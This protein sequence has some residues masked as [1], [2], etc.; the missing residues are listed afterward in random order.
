MRILLTQQVIMGQAGRF[1][2]GNAQPD[3][4][5]GF[6]NDLSY[7]GFSLSIFFYYVYGNEVYNN[8][9][10][11]IE[12]DGQRYGWNHLAAAGTDYWQQPGDIVS[13]PQP[14]PGGNNSSNSRSTRYI[15]DGSFLRLRNVTF[16]YNFPF[17]LLD[18][19][20]IQ[21]VRLYVQGQ[22]LW[23]LTDYSGFDPEMD[24]SGSEFFRYPV[25][26]SFTFGIDLTF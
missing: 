7:Q 10:R 21:N 1:I 2:I 24:E 18:K 12:S 8:S 15:E 13:R 23:T 20:G 6:T 5:G 4:T 16:S 9:R 19:A 22:N 25:G 26:K 14:L 11:F 3:F 17:E